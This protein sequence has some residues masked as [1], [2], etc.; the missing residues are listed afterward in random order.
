MPQINKRYL[1]CAVYLY[2]SKDAARKGDRIGGTGF[3]VQKVS[4][5]EGFHYYVVTNSHVIREACSPVVRLNNAQGVMDF[6]ELT[7]DDWTHHPDGHDIAVAPIDIDI[8][9]FGF[10]P[11]DTSTFVSLDRLNSDDVG[12]G[13]DVF[14]VGRLINHEGQQRNAPSVR[15]GNI[16]M[17]HHEPVKHFRGHMQQSFLVD[18]RSISGYSGSPVFVA[19]PKI[20]EHTDA[21]PYYFTVIPFHNINFLGVDWG[22]IPTYEKVIDGGGNKHPHGWRV[23]VNTGI[24]AVVPAWHLDELLNK[25]EFVVKRQREDRKRQQ[26]KDHE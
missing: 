23:Q 4:Q 10:Y 12:I 14:M 24:A 6:L 5:V 16:A 2:P 13:Q 21:L 15:F 20:I 19:Q 26:E 11:I 3:L 1:N 22:H 7:D 8:D 17:M 9:R 25:S 18:M